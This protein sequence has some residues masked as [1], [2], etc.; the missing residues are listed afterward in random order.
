MRQ[1]RTDHTGKKRSYFPKQDCLG[2]NSPNVNLS[3]NSARM[4]ACGGKN[5]AHSIEAKRNLSLLNDKQPVIL[6]FFSACAAEI[7]FSLPIS[8]V[9]VWLQPFYYNQVTRSRFLFNYTFNRTIQSV[10]KQY[11]WQSSNLWAVILGMPMSD[12]FGRF[13]WYALRYE[14]K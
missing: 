10:G 11:N 14:K 7:G 12:K 4:R 1:S 6:C 13:F 5:I 8:H 2:L 3:W 9:K